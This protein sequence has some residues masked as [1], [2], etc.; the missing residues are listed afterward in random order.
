MTAVGPLP[1]SRPLS[2]RSP[3]CQGRPVRCGAV[4]VVTGTVSHRDGWDGP[5]RGLRV[6][7][8]RRREALNRHVLQPGYH[9]GD[10]FEI[11]LDLILDALER[12]GT[13]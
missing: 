9:Y 5:D 11:G 7:G 1:V 4:P 6:T 13:P 10:E 2:L 3:S 8:R 12:A